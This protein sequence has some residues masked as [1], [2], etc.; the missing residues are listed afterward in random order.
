MSTWCGSS[1][2]GA[3]GIGRWRYEWEGGVHDYLVPMPCCC[4]QCPWIPIARLDCLWMLS[5]A[6]SR[7]AGS[8]SINVDR[9]RRCCT[10]T[11]VALKYYYLVLKFCSS[12]EKILLPSCMYVLLRLLQFNEVCCSNVY[13]KTQLLGARLRIM[14]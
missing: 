3:I 4:L 14:F 1:C 13:H 9:R 7:T 2:L 8:G 5:A 6:S 12:L 10:F 11:S